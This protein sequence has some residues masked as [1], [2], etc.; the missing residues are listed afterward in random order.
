MG[1]GCS[2]HQG[3]FRSCGIS[4]LTWGTEHIIR[5]KINTLSRL[6]ETQNKPQQAFPY[7]LRC[8]NAQVS[9]CANQMLMMFL[10]HRVILPTIHGCMLFFWKALSWLIFNHVL[11]ITLTTTISNIPV[12]FK[13]TAPPTPITEQYVV[14][15]W[16]ELQRKPL[17]HEP[18]AWLY[19]GKD[20]SST[21]RSHKLQKS[22]TQG[23]GAHRNKFK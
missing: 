1:T 3:G 15:I 6:E 19:S 21:R 10:Y 2:K 5:V 13:L 4:S 23:P 7:C 18:R 16:P 14:L 17:E 11:H 22:V 8:A 12:K 20:K 9:R